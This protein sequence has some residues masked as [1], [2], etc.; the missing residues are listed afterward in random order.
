RTI[1]PSRTDAD[2]YGVQQSLL[3]QNRTT[4]TIKQQNDNTI[5]TIR[6]D[7]AEKPSNNWTYE[8]VSSATTSSLPNG[9]GR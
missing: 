5:P 6:I 3:D 1:I 9:D 2:R 7:E 8:T 4:K